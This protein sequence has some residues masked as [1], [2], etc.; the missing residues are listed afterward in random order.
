MARL[1][2][3]VNCPGAVGNHGSASAISTYAAQALGVEYGTALIAVDKRLISVP[4][5]PD[6][7]TWVISLVITRPASSLVPL[8]YL[9][10]DAMA[11][12]AIKRSCDADWSTA[13]FHSLLPPT[14]TGEGRVS[15]VP[16]NVGAV[17][18][19]V[20]NGTQPDTSLVPGNTV[21]PATVTDS[22]VPEHVNAHV[23]SGVGAAAVATENGLASFVESNKV[24]FYFVGSLIGI[25]AIVV[26]VKNVR[27]IL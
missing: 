22:N 12:G 16:G 27:E 15:N 26:L 10:L 18:R 4:I 19:I 7:V 20:D 13:A 3:Y 14:G 23:N 5:F 1:T 24:P 11:F 17:G 8:D 25:V 21:I 6:K 9:H 2:Y